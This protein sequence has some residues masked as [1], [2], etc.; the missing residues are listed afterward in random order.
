MSSKINGCRRGVALPVARHNR[1]KIGLRD[2]LAAMSMSGGVAKNLAREG[3]PGRWRGQA[4]MRLGLVGMASDEDIAAVMDE[5]IIVRPDPDGGPPIEQPLR[6]AKAE[7]GFYGVIL[8]LPKSVSLLLTSTDAGEREAAEAAIQAASAA[9][10]A[11]L[12]QTVRTRIGAD[13][14]TS[15]AGSGLAAVEFFHHGSSAGDPHV[16]V[17]L[18][19]ANSTEGSDGRWRT[20]DSKLLFAAQRIATAAA[21]RAVQSTVSAALGLGPD[22]WTSALVG[23]VPT[24]EISA[25]RDAS[26]ILS[27]ASDRLWK[28][29]KSAGII[30]TPGHRLA[31]HLWKIDR[32]AGRAGY[33]RIE[34]G[35]DLVLAVGGE[36]AD[37]LRADWRALGGGALR[38]GF[39]ALRAQRGEM[40]PS[41]A[42]AWTPPSPTN[43]EIVDFIENSEIFTLS[44][45]AAYLVGRGIAT[46]KAL[47]AAARWLDTAADAA[48]VH[49]PGR[50]TEIA[51]ALRD[52]RLLETRRAHA[53]AGANAR[54]VTD[55]RV[56]HDARIVERLTQIARAAGRPLLV[57]LP[58]SAT[59]EQAAAI[60]LAAE[61]RRLAMIKG[62]AGAGKSFILQ[63]VTDAARRQRMEVFAI[64]RNAKTGNNLAHELGVRGGSIARFL[65]Q[66]H[67]QAAKNGER[68]PPTLIIVD[69][70]GVVDQDD[71]EALM[72]LAADPKHQVQIL[73]TGDRFQAQ[74][75][76]GKATWAL[77]ARA[78]EA[79]GVCVDLRT[80]FR[81]AAW[82]AE[83]AA[84]RAGDADT[85]IAAAGA[86]N[87]LK[88][89][90]HD[91]MASAAA[92][93][94]AA[95]PGS[96]VVCQT[97]L[98]ASII[99]SEIQKLRNIVG[100]VELAH[101]QRAG[102]GD[103]IRTR[104][105][106]YA[107]GVY[108]GDT[109]TV[110][111]IRADGGLSVQKPGSR[112]LVTL[113]AN[114]LSQHCELAYAATVD[115]AQGATVTR[116]IP[117]LTTAAGRNLSYS[118]ATRG[119]YAPVYLFVSDTDPP[120]TTIR[121]VL[122]RDDTVRAAIEIA[123]AGITT[124]AALAQP[125]QV[126]RT[127]TEAARREAVEAMD[128]WRL[129][130][131]AAGGDPETVPALARGN[132]F[133]DEFYDGM[134]A[135]LDRQQ[136]RENRLFKVHNEFQAQTAQ[137]GAMGDQVARAA[138][139]V[140]R[141]QRREP[142]RTA[143]LA[144]RQRWAG[145]MEVL[146]GRLAR[147]ERIFADWDGKLSVNETKV[148][149]IIA[150]I[151]DAQKTDN[152]A[153]ASATQRF[154]S[155][156]TLIIAEITDWLDGKEAAT[157][158]R[159]R[160]G[161]PIPGLG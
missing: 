109:W 84:L 1:H 157:R 95:Y 10:L 91:K 73:L 112:R 97:N 102:I 33:E 82:A 6:G 56:R 98:E 42:A 45:L 114:Y 142:S 27:R 12:E 110:T 120:E 135:F 66:H 137:V 133:I 11:T 117:V 148:F 20:I 107:I 32:Q 76:D 152:E 52:G 87:R 36:A 140:E 35:I 86:E 74:A 119:R 22:A 81:N 72:D 100:L 68:M 144:A 136:A 130:V 19:I 50:L 160:G 61:G 79:A 26:D 105:N 161:R 21:M 71:F 77:A 43:Q 88:S 28:Q 18:M 58:S 51:Q 155:G 121:G 80:S 101:D 49:G 34:A 104:Q 106:N 158:M 111:N 75:I 125:V 141:E 47:I 150:E 131:E 3:L 17:H 5:G 90:T 39:E 92:A 40:T 13:G 143:T 15:I 113:D 67:Y 38:V 83:A 54:I 44:D 46:D 118:G 138:T 9:Y 149:R 62:V 146:T 70:G 94:W 31:S 124:A 16:H 156:M 37:A 41:A 65:G 63:P 59:M 69:E 129:R 2:A 96:L 154:E 60:A 89:A 116:T 103:Q 64:T 147:Y 132:K 53:L 123:E 145:R 128:G 29:R 115:S 93:L 122:N 8:A 48:A 159:K 4:A 78:C 99:S 24:P 126:D 151:H 108:N 55:T 127:Q 23:S 57:A 7:I 85:V 30:G 14:A 134:S 153:K 139:A 25:L